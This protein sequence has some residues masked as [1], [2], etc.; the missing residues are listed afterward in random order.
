MLSTASVR[1]A[2]QL[3]AGLR[4]AYTLCG[5][6]PALL[7]AT[8]LE[9]RGGA[10]VLRLHRRGGVFAGESVVRRV[11]TLALAMGLEP[12]VETA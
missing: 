2:E 11:E 1:R 7:G 8:E 12:V 4:L 10:L 9:R 5:G 6:V 3:G